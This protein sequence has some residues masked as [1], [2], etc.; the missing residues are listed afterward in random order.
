MKDLDIRPI[1]GNISLENYNPDG[2]WD[3]TETSCIRTEV[4]Y[5]SCQNEVSPFASRPKGNL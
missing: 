2:E 1:Y 4:P 5:A 3:I